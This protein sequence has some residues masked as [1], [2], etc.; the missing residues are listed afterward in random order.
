[1]ERIA[2]R[3]AILVI[4]AHE[5]AARRIV[6]PTNGERSVSRARDSTIAGDGASVGD[7]E[8]LSK[9]RP[10]LSAPL[11]DQMSRLVTV[12]GAAPFQQ[13]DR[14]STRIV[15][16]RRPG[17]WREIDAVGGEHGPVRTHVGEHRRRHQEA[18]G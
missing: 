4:H 8:S 1:M 17:R 12:L 11:D 2:Q 10:I 16:A 18:A 3:Y 6:H 15:A 9:K 7:T 14:H 5:K 13:R